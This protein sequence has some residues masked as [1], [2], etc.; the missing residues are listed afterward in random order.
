MPIFRRPTKTPATPTP[1]PSSPID[2]DRPSDKQCSASP[3]CYWEPCRPTCKGWDT[4]E[5][6]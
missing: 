6:G 2:P 5:L 4:S 1:K 3:S